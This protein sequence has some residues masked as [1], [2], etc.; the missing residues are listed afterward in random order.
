MAEPIKL[1]LLIDTLQTCYDKFKD[2][3]N[4]DSMTV[5]FWHGEKELELDFIGQ[6]QIV[7]DVTIN[8][9]V[10]EDNEEG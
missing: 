6:F 2:N 7:P 8:F 10:K 1:K 9:K 4:P 3:M 5:E